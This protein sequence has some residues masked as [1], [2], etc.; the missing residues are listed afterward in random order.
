MHEKTEVIIK[1]TISLNRTL[2]K[3]Q[4]FILINSSLSCLFTIIIC[5]V[6]MR[7]GFQR[8]YDEM[9]EIFL[10]VPAAYTILERWVIRCRQSGMIL[11]HHNR[12]SHRKMD[13]KKI[14]VKNSHAQA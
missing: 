14:F 10:D 12:G 7:E 3:L 8:V 11:L 13:L 6:K 4:E 1:V 5:F 2:H 9:P